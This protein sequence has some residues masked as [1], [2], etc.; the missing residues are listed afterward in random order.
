MKIEMEP[1]A[2]TVTDETLRLVAIFCGHS[3]KDRLL[4]EG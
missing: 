3:V 4:F 1:M 2:A